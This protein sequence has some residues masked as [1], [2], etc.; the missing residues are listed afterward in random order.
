MALLSVEDALARLIGGAA[1][2]SR[3]ET[4]DLFDA[5]GRVLAEPVS[6]S[7]TQPPFDNSAMD[8]YALRAED[9]TSL[10][11]RLDVIGESAAGR[12]FAGTVCKGQ[13]VRIFTG[14]PMPDGADTV[15]LQ[16]DAIRLEGNAIETNFVVS[17]GRHV[18]P[19]GQDFLEGEVVLNA[20]EIMDAGRLTVAAAMNRPG[21]TVYR[22]PL[23]AVVATGDELVPAGTAPGPDQIVASSIYGVSALAKA[24]GADVLYL[25]IVGD[26]R[27]QIERA[28]AKA[29]EARADVIVTLGGASVGDHDLIQPVLRSIGMELDFW[30]IAMRPG[31]PLMVGSLGDARVLGLPGNPV[32]SMV[33]S[34]LFLE[35]LVAHLAHL[36]R[37]E[38]RA[39][40]VAAI[41]LANND[42][43]QDYLRAK[44]VRRPDGVLEARSFGK[45]DSSQMKIFARADCLIVRA[46]NAEALA[47]GAEC[48]IL[49]LRQPI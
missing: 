8:G 9:V 16:E 2:I 37:P 49:T 6:A 29:Q 19:R 13:A 25:G 39:K 46:P 5:D 21:V 24:A 32:S 47:A 4:I 1:R 10:G 23:V 17:K 12:R 31:K 26:D 36:P 30:K 38:R 3:S 22:K 7:L 27:S 35:P 15:L 20:G 34:L 33:C 45:Q 14:A 41:A 48:S 11:T 28:V 43:R 40:A 42:H 44:L 18:R